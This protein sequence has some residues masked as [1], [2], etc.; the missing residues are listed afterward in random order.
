TL[1][2][3]IAYRKEKARNARA[4]NIEADKAKIEKSQKH[5]LMNI[6]KLK[7]NEFK[8]IA[9]KRN[10]ILHKATED[11]IS[12]K[13]KLREMKKNELESFYN[14]RSSLMREAEEYKKQ[15]EKEVQEWQQEQKNLIEQLKRN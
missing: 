5:A 4:K 3:Y 9:K 14:E 13:N 10:E 15:K 12:Q 11:L 2:N 7:R 6:E 8:R 1:K